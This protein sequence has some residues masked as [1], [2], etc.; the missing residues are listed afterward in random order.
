MREEKASPDSRN[1]IKI[2][3]T[4]EAFLLPKKRKI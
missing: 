1:E 4:R 3:G 2:I